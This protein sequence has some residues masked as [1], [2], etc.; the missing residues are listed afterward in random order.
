MSK[1]I[2]NDYEYNILFQY[3]VNLIKK[4]PDFL[5]PYEY[6]LSLLDLLESDEELEV[7]LIE[8]CERI[9][10]KREDF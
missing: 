3:F 8:A 1:E 5:K 10:K 6:V 2:S 9:A 7:R 4:A